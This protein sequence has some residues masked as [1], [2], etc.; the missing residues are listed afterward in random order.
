M[1]ALLSSDV[2]APVGAGE[3]LQYAPPPGSTL[4]GGNIDVSLVADGYGQDA[5][6][7]AVLYTPTPAYDA[8]DVF[9]QCA[10]G[11]PPC[12]TNEFTGVLALPTDRGGDLYLSA[13][14]GG[15]TGQYCNQGATNGAWSLVQ[16]WW[17][18]LLLNN[19]STPAATGFSGPLLSA[20]AHG[21]ADIAFTATDPNGPGVYT[22]AVE[23]D[24]QPVYDATPNTNQGNCHPV[25]T[26]ATTGALM[27][28]NQQP[29][30]QTETIDIPVDTTALTDGQHDLKVTVTDAA[31]NTST[32]LD[33]TIT[34]L[35]HPAPSPP[36]PTIPAITA[37]PVY[38]L[39]LAPATRRLTHG[40]HRRYTHSTLKLAGTL[41]NASGVAAPNIPVALWA[42]PASG[43]NFTQVAQTTTDGGGAWTLTAPPG[44]S[45]LL[46]IVT[47]ADAHPATATT[48]ISVRETVSPV[49][50]LHVTTPGRHRIIF[51]GHLTIA[52]LGTPR[53][54]YDPLRRDP[55]SSL[56]PPA[57]GMLATMRA[58]PLATRAQPAQRGWIAP[59]PQHA[60][61]VPELG[62]RWA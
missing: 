54:L 28:D 47:G 61:P 41:D 8:G 39:A 44:A 60:P 50:S 33:Q 13:G 22:V 36:P 45:R 42:Q 15:L 9:Y 51:N 53:P 40:V 7:T 48:S 35:N 10:N 43:G 46:T 29:C 59:A 57:P 56:P 6:A 27:F 52:P 31:Q 11:Q 2:T 26:D 37:P 19:T 4:V 34:T 58:P 23:I 1:F 18:D 16:L 32:V 5:S 14:C 38:S 12:P 30:P 62:A 24:G 49:L 21:T 17:A 25:A 20:N 3:T 55:L